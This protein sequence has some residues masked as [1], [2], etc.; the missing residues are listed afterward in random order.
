MIFAA[1]DTVWLAIVGGAMVVVKQILD[2]V[3]LWLKDRADSRRAKE[4]QIATDAA[5][6]TVKIAVDLKDEKQTAHLRKQDEAI[7]VV[8]KEGNG[9]QAKLVEEVRKAAFAMGVKSETD[10]GPIK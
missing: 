3:S 1:S 4:L 2:W 6:G 9:N 5:A 7:E 10:K 8:R